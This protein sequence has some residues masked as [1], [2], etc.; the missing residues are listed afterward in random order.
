MNKKS[1]ILIAVLVALGAF[2]V[3]YFS[4]WFKPK[5]I[6]ISH[7]QRF[8]HINFSLGSPYRLTAV[9]VISVT[10]LESNKYALPVWE[11]KSDS[12]SAPT[13]IFSY[14]GRIQGMKPIVSNARPDPLQP[15]NAYR[16]FV[17]AGPIKAQH[18]FT[19]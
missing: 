19:P 4:N 10:A 11:L 3:V 15:G 1:W 2:Y 13:K 9:K 12:N 5:V 6:L 17:E 7:D 8:G 18:D 14:G 16:L